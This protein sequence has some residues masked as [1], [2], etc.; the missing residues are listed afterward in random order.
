[1]GKSM[2]LVN[3]CFKMVMYM[4]GTGLMGREKEMEF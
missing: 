2:V 1:M 4:K 3:L